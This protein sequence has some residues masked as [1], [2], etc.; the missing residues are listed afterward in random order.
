MLEFAG[1]GLDHII[2]LNVYLSAKLTDE[3]EALFNKVYC[4]VFPVEAERPLRCCVRVTLQPG[5]DV[6][7]VNVMAAMK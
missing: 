6:E 3:E 5:F 7:V 4:E 2:S 1:S